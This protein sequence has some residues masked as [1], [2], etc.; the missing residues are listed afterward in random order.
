VIGLKPGIAWEYLHV[1]EVELYD[2]AGTRI[3]AGLKATASS[4]V[5]S[6]ELAA[7]VLDGNP[8][9]ICHTIELDAAAALTVQ[10]RCPGGATTLSRV[11]ITNR[12]GCC[13]DRLNK[14]RLK[15]INSGGSED[16]EAF[17]FVNSRASYT[18]PAYSGG[19]CTLLHPALPRHV[20][21]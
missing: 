16:R 21:I 12:V 6:N 5:S 14:F 7:N 18:I 20:L 8:G 1:A 15:F 11:V 17:D 10:Y 2:S 9:T 19:V 3:T 13:R 4:T